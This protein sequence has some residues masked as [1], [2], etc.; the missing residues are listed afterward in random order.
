MLHVT[1]DRVCDCPEALESAALKRIISLNVTDQGLDDDQI[2]RL[3]RSPH[4][5][6]LRWLGIALNKITQRGLDAICGSQHLKGLLYLECRGNA[7]ADPTDSFGTEGEAVV[8]SMPTGPAVPAIKL[9]LRPRRERIVAVALNCELRAANFV[10]ATHRTNR[11]QDRFAHR[12]SSR[13]KRRCNAYARCS[14]MT[15]GGGG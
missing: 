10:T 14:T 2:E 7:F 12:G 6:R 15:G 4:S 1:L 8:F 13:C 11:S 5:R 9:V 3:A